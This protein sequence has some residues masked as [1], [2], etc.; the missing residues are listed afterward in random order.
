M[1]KSEEMFLNPLV[2]T[3]TVNRGTGSDE[4]AVEVVVEEADIR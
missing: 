4:G 3:E 2:L 1:N